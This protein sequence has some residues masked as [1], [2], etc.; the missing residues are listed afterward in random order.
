MDALVYKRMKMKYVWKNEADVFVK[1]GSLVEVPYVDPSFFEVLMSS[2]WFQGIIA[3]ERM[4]WTM[5]Y[6]MCNMLGVF[7]Q[8]DKYDD[9]C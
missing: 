3:Y 4:I 7:L 1:E 9:S 6:D 5:W 2:P 8:N